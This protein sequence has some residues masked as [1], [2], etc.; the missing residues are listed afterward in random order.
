MKGQNHHL[1]LYKIDGVGIDLTRFRPVYSKDEKNNLRE[2]HGFGSEDFVLIYTA[3]F[4][5]R[6]NHKLIFDILPTL[7]EYIPELKMILCGKGELLDKYQSLAEK[8]GMDSYIHFTGYT[9]DVPEWYRLSDVLVMP[10][11][12][13]GLPIAM[14]EAV[15]TGLPAV[16]SNIRGQVDIIQDCVNGFLFKPD[17]ANSFIKAIYT[18]YKNPQLRY[19]MS[20]RNVELA[21]RFSVKS[22]ISSMA[23]IYLSVMGNN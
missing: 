12:Q 16:A 11:F 9:T 6:K 17:D 14:V 10:S 8:N 22:A 13:E 23:K 1:E 4:I 18:L 7:K 21:K 19:E 3:E 20:R 5:P 2:M 15:A